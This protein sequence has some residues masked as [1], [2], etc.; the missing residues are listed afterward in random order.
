VTQVL[1]LFWPTDS[2]IAAGHP[3][4]FVG[5]PTDDRFTHEARTTLLAP[6]VT[7]SLDGCR[8]GVLMWFGADVCGYLADMGR[9]GEV[10]VIYTEE[11][12]QRR[13]IATLMYEFALRFEPRMHHSPSQSTPGALWARRYEH[14]HGNPYYVPSTHLHGVPRV[15]ELPPCGCGSCVSTRP[16]RWG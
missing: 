3:P 11:A 14:S 4:A 9:V 6:A 7:A 13:G 12:F 2:A 10:S 1:L 15:D 16:R 5:A 8:V